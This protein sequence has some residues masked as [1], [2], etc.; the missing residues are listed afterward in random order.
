MTDAEKACPR[1]VCGALAGGFDELL[2]REWLITNGLGGYASGTVIGCPTRRYHGLLVVSR[3][4]PLERIVLWAQTVDQLVVGGKTYELSCFEFSDVV[5]PKGYVWQK[6]FDF[7]ARQ[8]V[9]WV[10]FVYSIGQVE[11]VKRVRLADGHNTVEIGYDVF[12]P[13]GEEVEVNVLPLVAGRDFHSLLGGG[14]GCGWDMQEEGGLVWLKRW[15]FHDT[16][17][18]MSAEAS[19]GGAEAGFEPVRDWWYRFHYRQEV[20]RGQDCREDL[21]TPGWFRSKGSG[22]WRLELMGVGCATGPAEAGEAMESARESL[23]RGRAVQRVEAETAS[24]AIDDLRV[25][26]LVAAAGQFLVRR[27]MRDGRRLATILAGYPWFGDWGRDAFISLP[28]L[29]LTTGRFEEAKEVL[30]TFASA[31][32]NGLIPNRFDD[33]GGQC[34]YNS[35]DASLW[36]V[37]AADAYVR[38]THD[39]ETWKECLGPACLQVVEAFERGTD[40]DIGVDRDGLLRCGNP[41]TQITWMDA[42]SGDVVFTPRHG[43]PVEINAL[44]Y[45]AL[46][47]VADRLSESCDSRGFR[48]ETKAERVHQL[49]EPAFWNEATGGLNDCV[50]EEGPDPAIRPNQIFAVSLAHSPLSPARQRSVVACV[51]EH[52]LTPYGLRTLSPADSRYRG[53]YEGGPFERD[54]AYHQGTVWPW[55]LGPFVEA[56]LRVHNFEQGARDHCRDLL[57]GLLDHLVEAG[58]GTVSEVYDGDAPHRPAGCI[59][60]AWSVAETLRAWA[61]IHSRLSVGPA[62]RV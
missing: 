32:H 12:A 43:K 49:F 11:L 45:H 30:T 27:S 22:R 39:L 58:L 41:S 24:S 6:D 1:A 31:Q 9:P 13:D 23:A 25:E 21:F 10:Q 55:L 34:Q 16:T 48:L 4:P 28:G 18:V 56:Y 46:C 60:Q 36:F 35:V 7:S 29:L 5:H 2:S 54:G 51:E 47:I 20:H 15:G 8:P 33:Y 59:A 26:P 44:W 61:L 14:Q 19:G 42:K 53:R 52:L 50:R 40:F 3:R 38:Q 37:H 62:I 57:A 17:L